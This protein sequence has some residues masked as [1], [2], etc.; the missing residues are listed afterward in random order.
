MHCSHSRTHWSPFLEQVPPCNH[1]PQICE[2]RW[3]P[4]TLET[5]WGKRGWPPRA[6]CYVVGVCKRRIFCPGPSPRLCMWELQAFSGPSCPPN[7]HKMLSICHT[8]EN[9]GSQWNEGFLAKAKLIQEKIRSIDHSPQKG[10]Q[11]ANKGNYP[12]QNLDLL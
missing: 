6:R 4:G 10:Q 5:A 12:R 1:F 8:T 3:N 9:Q 7:L 2:L 11:E